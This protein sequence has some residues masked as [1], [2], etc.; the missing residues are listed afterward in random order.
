MG[1]FALGRLFHF[2]QNEWA[3][4]RLGGVDWEAR[5]EFGPNKRKVHNKKCEKHNPVVDI[6][7]LIYPPPSFYLH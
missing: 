4:D 7:P 1:S 6:L 3:D 5:Y 2:Y